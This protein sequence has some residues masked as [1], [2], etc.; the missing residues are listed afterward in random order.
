MISFTPEQEQFM[1]LRM[2]QAYHEGIRDGIHQ[3]AHWR[4]GTQYVG[5][6][7]RTLR[8]ALDSVNQS[9]AD[10]LDRY[11]ELKML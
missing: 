10:L 3:Y 4:D 6:T 7:G 8:E 1:Q 2:T 11:N 9:E 5:T